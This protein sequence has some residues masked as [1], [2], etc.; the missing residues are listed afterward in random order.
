MET[1]LNV[2]DARD[3]LKTENIQ[4]IDVRSEEQ[5]QKKSLPNS[6]NIP[7]SKISQEI[8]NLDAKKTTLLIC[9]DGNL[10]I[11]ASRLLEACKFRVYTIRGGIV[12]WEQIIGM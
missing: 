1:E 5:F 4:L 7:L 10:S 9:N 11:Q 6:I 3:M 2:I 12:D 8:P